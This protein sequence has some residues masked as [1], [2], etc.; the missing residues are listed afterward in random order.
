MLTLLRQL[1]FLQAGAFDDSAITVGEAEVTGRSPDGII[2][3]SVG[4]KIRGAAPASA[5]AIPY[6]HGRRGAD[7]AGVSDCP[8]NILT[9]QEIETILLEEL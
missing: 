2:D 8:R 9:D 6:R 3:S 1:K 5:T 7:G 4:G